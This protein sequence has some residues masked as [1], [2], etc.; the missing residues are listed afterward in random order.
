M[1]EDWVNDWYLLGAT[2][3]VTDGTVGRRRVGSVQLAVFSRD[4]NF[5][6]ARDACITCRASLA[7]GNV[8]DDAVQCPAC[9]RWLRFT[10][11]PADEEDLLATYPVMVVN[12]EVF[13][14]IEGLD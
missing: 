2:S 6:A 1:N 3:D 13:A 5:F 7:G 11:E 10:S 9:D 12:E 14:W 8:R 4:G